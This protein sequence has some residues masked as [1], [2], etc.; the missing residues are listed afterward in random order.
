MLRD[1]VARKTELGVKAKAIMNAGGLVDDDIMVGIID[2]Q[3][4]N[5][6]ECA[7]GLVSRFLERKELIAKVGKPL[8]S[9]LMDSLELLCKLR[10]LILCFLL[11][12]KS[13]IMLFN[14]SS[15]TAFLLV[16]LLVDSFIQLLDDLTT[17]NSS[18][19]S[20]HYS[21]FFY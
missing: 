21:T 11:N 18:T 3:L 6:K 19:F 14:F 17:R 16:G 10:S 7:L 5:N 15:M 1:Q 9:F 12:H 8:V 20:N 4:T 13:S 2:D